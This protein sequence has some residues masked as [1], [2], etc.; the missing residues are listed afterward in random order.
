MKTKCKKS[1]QAYFFAGAAGLAPAAGAAPGAA[2]AASAGMSSLMI[3]SG[4]FAASSAFLISRDSLPTIVSI[5][6]FACLRNSSFFLAS[7]SARRFLSSSSFASSSAE[8]SVFSRRISSSNFPAS[9]SR[10]VSRAGFPSARTPM[11]S[12]VPTISLT[13]CLRVLPS[14]LSAFILAILMICSMRMS[15]TFSVLGL[16]EPFSRWVSFLMRAEAGGVPTEMSNF[17]VSRSTLTVTGTCM[18][19]NSAVLLLMSATTWPMLTPRGPRAGPSGGAAVAL[20]PSTNTCM[21][22]LAMCR[23]RVTGTMGGLKAL[24]RIRQIAVVFVVRVSPDDLDGVHL[25]LHG[26]GDGRLQQLDHHF[27]LGLVYPRDLGL[28]ALERPGDDLHDVDRKSTRLNSS[29]MSTSY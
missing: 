7:A 21:F 13:L 23:Y 10:M 3:S 12:H 4:I 15:A 22:S 14:V 27:F 28:L 20:P 25:E 5:I 16:P 29:H 24:W 9:I 18:P 19:L 11:L 17:L 2:A 1:L 8:S 6:V 26:D